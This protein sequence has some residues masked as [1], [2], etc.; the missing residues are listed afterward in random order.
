MTDQTPLTAASKASQLVI[1]AATAGH[2]P[3]K[4]AQT[5]NLVAG[6]LASGAAD[7]ATALTGDFRTGFLLGTSPRKQFIAQ[8][9]GTFCAVWLAPGMFVLFTTAY[10]CIVD[11]SYEDCQFAIPSVSAWMAVAQAVTDPDVHI[12]KSAGI[13][14]IVSSHSTPAAPSDS[15]SAMMC[16][17]ETGTK[18]SAPR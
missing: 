1:G 6:G 18:S 7:V 14:A 13:F 17:C 16:A 5:V 4:Q 9:I 11:S 8:A 3:I 12:P 15:V 10:P 2:Y